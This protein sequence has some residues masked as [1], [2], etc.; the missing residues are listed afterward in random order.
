MSLQYI[1]TIGSSISWTTLSPNKPPP[2]NYVYR[3]PPDLRNSVSETTLAVL[4]GGYKAYVKEVRDSLTKN[5]RK[6]EMAEAAKPFERVIQ[7]HIMKTDDQADTQRRYEK[8]IL[9][10]SLTH[11]GF[12]LSFCPF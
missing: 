7:K 12:F 6:S 11:V 9:D 5:L 3:M 8:P 1:G 4:E 2:Y 10:I